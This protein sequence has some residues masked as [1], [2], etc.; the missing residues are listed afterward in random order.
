MKFFIYFL[1]MAIFLVA[2]YKFFAVDP[3]MGIMLA[4]TGF[5]S[6]AFTLR[7]LLLIKPSKHAD[8]WELCGVLLIFANA[9]IIAFMDYNSPA[10][11]W[12]DIPMHFWGG[13]FAAWWASIAFPRETLDG[14]KRFIVILGMAALVGVV[15]EM[16]E[17]VGDHTAGAWLNLPVAQV[18]LNDTMGDL[19]NDLVGGVMIVIILNK[20][21]FKIL[22][23]KDS[24]TP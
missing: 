7:K 14:A 2:F 5:F 15:W 18:S 21:F 19:L 13:V 1:R 3:I 24:P 8:Y 23:L 20:K 17:W 12:V 10:N 9:L 4:G 16:F 22:S 6:F 11:G